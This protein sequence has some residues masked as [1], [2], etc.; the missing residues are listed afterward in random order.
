MSELRP[1]VDSCVTLSDC[2]DIHS[3]NYTD[4]VSRQRELY[5]S[6]SA[7]ASDVTD[8]A[9]RRLQHYD[10]SPSQVASQQSSD[11]SVY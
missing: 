3:A 9:A 6:A 4:S 7:P 11:V 10:S 8:A 5:R 2:P 1:T